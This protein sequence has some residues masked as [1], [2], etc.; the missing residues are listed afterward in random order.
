MREVWWGIFCF[1]EFY[2]V[3]VR[4]CFVFEGGID[5][6]EFLLCIGFVELIVDNFFV[7]VVFLVLSGWRCYLYFYR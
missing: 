7:F 3:Y 6:L 2:G 1:R 4:D 5:F